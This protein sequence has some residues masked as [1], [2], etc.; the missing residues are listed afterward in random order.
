MSDFSELCP[1]FNTGVYHE[2]FLGRLTAS[3]YTS[4][5]LNYFSSPGDP[6]TAPISLNF[7]RTV[8]VTNCYVRRK[9]AITTATI[10]LQFGRRTGSGTVDQSIFALLK[11]AEDTTTFPDKDGAWQQMTMTACMTLHTADFLSMNDAVGNATNASFDVIVQYRE[12]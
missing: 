7:G 3:L 9:G 12:K 6:A 8:V 1:I 11:F 5:T 4:A 2:L 10:S